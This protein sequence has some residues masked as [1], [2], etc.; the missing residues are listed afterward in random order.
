MLAS[1]SNSADV[2]AQLVWVGQGTAKEIE[3]AEVEGKIVVEL[4]AV[5]ELTDI[6]LAQ[7]LS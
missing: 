7:I 6:H 2:K 5:K 1:G 3:A 4:K